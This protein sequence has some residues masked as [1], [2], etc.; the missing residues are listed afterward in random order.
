MCRV[1]NIFGE[2]DGS[3]AGAEGWRGCD[4]GLQGIEEAST[5]EK[6]E[7]GGGFAARNNKAVEV[8]KFSRSSDE[9]CTS[10]EGCER[11]GVGFECALQGEYADGQRGLGHY[12]FIV[13]KRARVKSDRV[14]GA[15]AG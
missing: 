14:S 7:E 13:E 2:E 10:A 15:S 11:F 8:F 6:L 9:L 12:V 5:L 4:E 1:L 3:R